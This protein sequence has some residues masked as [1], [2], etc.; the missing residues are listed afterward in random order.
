[1]CRSAHCH[2]AALGSAAKFG[3][4]EGDGMR[5]CQGEES[6]GF[7]SEPPGWGRGN[8]SSIAGDRTGGAGL[9][10]GR[11]TV[12]GRSAPQGGPNGDLTVEVRRLVTSYAGTQAVRAIDLAIGRGA[13][14]PDQPLHHRHASRFLGRSFAWTDVLVLGGWGSS[15][16]CSRSA[17]S[18]GSRAATEP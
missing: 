4:H 12:A 14:F 5:Q 18:A 15:D 6:R 9:D 11:G 13:G 7:S 10:S 2:M 3:R 17:S 1:M 8:G 16:S